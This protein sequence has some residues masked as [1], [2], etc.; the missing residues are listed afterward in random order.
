MK[1]TNV[2][3]TR[4]EPSLKAQLFKIF[5]VKYQ[6]V[7]RRHDIKY[8]EKSFLETASPHKNLQKGKTRSEGQGVCRR[9]SGECGGQRQR[10][11]LKI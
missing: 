4:P 8:M 9:E 1:P 10:H 5:G 11:L 3:I 7:L 2:T 6:Q